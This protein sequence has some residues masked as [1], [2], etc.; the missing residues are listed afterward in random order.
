MKSESGYLTLYK[1]DNIRLVS[2]D[3]GGRLVLTKSKR[4]VIAQ[5]FNPSCLFALVCTLLYFN[6]K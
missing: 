3:N 6:A 2:W 1:N 4:D 5:I